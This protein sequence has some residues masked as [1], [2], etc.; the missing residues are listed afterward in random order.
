[1]CG[2]CGFY[3]L[4]SDFVSYEKT[5]EMV[6]KM[7]DSLAHRGPDGEGQWVDMDNRIALGHRRLSIL[8]L[9]NNGSQPMV[10]HS[11]RYV[12]SYNGELYNYVE[13]S[14]EIGRSEGVQFTS[15]CDTE[16]LLELIEKRGIKNALKKTMGMFGLAVFDR[17]DKK[18]YLVRD[19]FG[20]KSIYYG[21]NNG[22]FIFGSE[23][24]AIKAFQ[25]FQGELDEDSVI[26]FMKYRSIKAPWSIYRHIN[27]LLPGEIVSL[28]L[29]TREVTHDFY[30]DL[31]EEAVQSEKNMVTASLE[32]C[33]DE[34]ERLLTLTIKRQLR[35]DV[36]VGLFLSRGIDSA[37]VSA[38]AQKVSGVK[39]RTYTIGSHNAM[40][41]EAPLAR[42]YSE[43]I[44]TDHTEY[45]PTV[46]EMRDAVVKL[47]NIF[48]EPFGQ[49]VS[50]ASYFLA[51]IA[52]RDVTVVITG[53]GADE[54]F[55][56]YPRDI[57]SV[58]EYY[59]MCLSSESQRFENLN[60]YLQYN[61]LKADGFRDEMMQKSMSKNRNLANFGSDRLINDI[62]KSIYMEAKTFLESETLVKVDRT[63]MHHSLE[64]REPF[65][66]QDVANF[67]YR[68]PL[69]YKYGAGKTKLIL[70]KLLGRYLP[71]KLF[72][73]PKQGFIIP[74]PIYSKEFD[75]I[76][77]TVFDR[78]NIEKSGLFRTDEIMREI[79]EKESKNSKL[80]FNLFMLQLWLN[81]ND[82]ISL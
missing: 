27:R 5:L 34:L 46:E 25:G 23:L 6:R 41:D 45:Y 36:P 65:L 1:M 67:A 40:L 52:K 26:S 71:E 3:G 61:I 12:I 28:D 76:R 42:K 70:R 39:L 20:E 19:R 29:Q 74:V 47:T 9:S 7:S 72:D 68:L 16:V 66:Y 10:S 75:D 11:G 8:D 56:G 49:Q 58:A 62:N 53:E 59:A 73:L 44:G 48:D 24:K 33:V 18:L 37:L 13:L 57:Y 78:K 4:K 30:Y 51:K 31:E 64:V 17:Q 82:Y 43:I 35:S 54:L 15:S 55:V 50:V 80:E 38:I 22:R 69:V 60:D 79:G 32:E 14:A 2:I 21:W 77:R 63:S 81:E